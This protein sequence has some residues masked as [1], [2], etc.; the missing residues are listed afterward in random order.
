MRLAAARGGMK[1][2]VTGLVR[3][4][5][6]G[7]TGSRPRLHGSPPRRLTAG[8]GEF[9]GE[10]FL[11][12]L[13]GGVISAAGGQGAGWLF[14]EV[15]FNSTPAYVSQIEDQLKQLAAQMSQLEDEIKSVNEAVQ[16]TYYATE[17]ASLVDARSAI[18]TAM[19]HMALVPGITNAA[20]REYWSDQY[21]D[22]DVT[23]L[24]TDHDPWGS[25]LSLFNS[26]LVATPPGEK[27]LVQQGA[28]YIKSQGS[29]WTLTKSQQVWEI[30]D[31]W[32]QYAVEWLDVYLEYEH[33]P[34]IDG[35][36]HCDDPATDAGCPLLHETNQTDKL[37]NNTLATLH[38]QQGK[39]LQPLPAYQSA[40]TPSGSPLTSVPD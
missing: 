32:T 37:G 2:L 5:R 20:D 36:A 21:F 1:R 29:F 8:T 40:P 9:G 17:S 16:E 39:P 27:P 18:D 15:G 25:T 38:D 35:Q 6:R 13:A 28:Y 19:E 30:A 12:Q 33:A 26:V 23:P 14:N 34:Q 22:Q 10:W 11:Q 24:A 3:A 4:V 7:G 31:F